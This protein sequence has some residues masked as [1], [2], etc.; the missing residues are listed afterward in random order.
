MPLKGGMGIL[1]REGFPAGTK[2]RKIRPEDLIGRP[3]MA[4]GRGLVQN[5]LANW[6]G[7]YTDQI[8]IFLP[9]TFFIIRP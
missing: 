8:D 2:K 3:L 7:E 6:F 9:I 5:E 4:S 1:V